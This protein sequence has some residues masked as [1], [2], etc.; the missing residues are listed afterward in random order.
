LLASEIRKAEF[1]EESWWSKW[2]DETVWV[3]RDAYAIFSNRFRDEDFFNHAGFLEPEG[4]A[5]VIVGL[6]EKEFGYREVPC[7]MFVQDGSQWD[8]LREVLS[9]RGYKVADVMS[10]MEFGRKEKAGEGAHRSAPSDPEVETIVLGSRPTREDLRE[11]SRA[12]LEAFYG[13]VTL[14][15][16]VQGIMEK[17]VGD[18]GTMATSLVLARTRK[19]TVGCASLHRTGDDLAGAFCIGTVPDFRQRGVGAAMLGCMLSLSE[20]EKR[21]LVL[22]T[23]VSDAAEGFYL[24]QGFGRAYSK[25]VF[26]RGGPGEEGSR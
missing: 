20:R 3:T 8:G 2:V 26:V 5:E 9:S 23:L 24:K 1:N 7:C 4:E 17:V 13:D 16:A 19:T 10:V 25:S 11:W 14:L 22:Q 12:Y 6:I 21:K 18:G 15:D